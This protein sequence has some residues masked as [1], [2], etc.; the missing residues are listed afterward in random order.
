MRPSAKPRLTVRDPDPR[1][2]I[3]FEANLAERRAVA[4]L[5]R[6]TRAAAMAHGE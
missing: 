1:A 6:W 4:E 5:V 3:G 2:A